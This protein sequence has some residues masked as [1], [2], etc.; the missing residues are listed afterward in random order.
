MADAE[1][2]CHCGA[3]RW[4][5]RGVP[6]SATACNCTVCSRYGALWAY[7]AEGATV[8]VSGSTGSYIPEGALAF[9]FCTNCGCL[10]HYTSLEPDAQG[11]RKMAVNLRMG[12]PR[13]LANVP[14]RRW[15]GR[16]S[17]SAMAP[18]GRT[19]ADHWF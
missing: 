8:E 5:Y 12:D 15:D 3:V 6:D 4:R 7:G 1:G 18:D 16:D 2:A 9:H 14:V 10:T 17:W 11:V 19:L 13:Q